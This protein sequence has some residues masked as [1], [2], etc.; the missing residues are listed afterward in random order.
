MASDTDLLAQLFTEAR[1]FSYWQDRPVDRAEIEAAFTLA[2]HGPT[3]ANCEP[4]RLVLV[5]S[6]EAR[7]GCC[8]ACRR[9]I[10]RR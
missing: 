1:T 7:S 9:A 5:A 2:V 4:M 8:P 6:P 10:S 3:S